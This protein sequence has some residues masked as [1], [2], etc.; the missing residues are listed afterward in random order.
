MN[1]KQILAEVARRAKALPAIPLHEQIFIQAREFHDSALRCF[2][3][4]AGPDARSSFPVGPAVVS[5]AFA[6]ELYLKTLHVLENGKS[7]QGHRLNVL[8]AGL[9][10]GMQA[11]VRARYLARRPGRERYF[12]QDLLEYANAFVDHRYVYEMQAGSID[13]VGV[14][15]LASALYEVCHG[16]DATLIA[17]A[18]THALIV[19]RVQG[20]PRFQ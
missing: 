15:H 2:E 13:V 3:C 16:R 1:R 17:S 5:L 18:L 6:S 8:L 10:P 11:D 20:L 19:D 14:A 7:R 12:E 4:R 9:S